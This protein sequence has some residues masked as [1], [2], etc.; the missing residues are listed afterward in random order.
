MA[1]EAH[2]LRV[3]APQFIP[4]S[5][6]LGKATENS[7][8]MLGDVQ[9]R[10]FMSNPLSCQVAPLV[11]NPVVTAAPSE[12]SLTV[13]VSAGKKRT[14]ESV[15]FLGEDLSS[16][17]QNQMAELDRVLADHTERMRTEHSERRR[18]FSR[19]LAAVVED[20]VR[21]RLQA[22]E[23]EIERVKKLNWALEERIRT[24]FVE[25]QIWRELAQTNEA[26]ANLLRTNL[27]QVLA[28]QVS[29]KDEQRQGCDVDAG[30]GDAE[31]C[32]CGEKDDRKT[33][34]LAITPQRACRCCGQKEATVLLLACRHL[35]LCA[36][37]APATHSCP[38]CNCNKSGSVFINL[39]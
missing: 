11:Y 1:V 38:V 5:R 39:S 9:T 24:L 18:R 2:H 12:S 13:A 32:C 17:F 21:K 26:T 4:N 19:Q 22:K 34:A 27:E 20:G 15:S 33:V 14:R 3:L 30:A 10:F 6:E 29:F 36:G 7:S 28:A 25:N 16:L 35:C 23:Q 31:S 37:C 8:A